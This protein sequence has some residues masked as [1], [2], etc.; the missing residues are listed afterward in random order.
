MFLKT[1]DPVL[2]YN[3]DTEF[4]I[5][6]QGNP[7]SSIYDSSCDGTWLL[8]KTLYENTEKWD[9]N[10]VN[11]FATSHMNTWLNNTYLNQIVAKDIIKKVNL[12]YLPGGT[13]SSIQNMETSVF[14][15]GL[16]EVGADS[17]TAGWSTMPV[18]GA[19]LD[20]FTADVTDPSGAAAKRKVSART[21]GTAY[22]WFRSPLKTSTGNVW[23][24]N[25]DGHFDGTFSAV[26]GNSSI[27]PAFIVS[28]D[29]M[30]AADGTIQV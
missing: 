25:P 15:L 20:Y 22:W 26:S 3:V 8:K 29:T 27:R 12:P 6:H 1:Y 5:V 23:N 19:K 2:E 9:T 21:G 7:D 11:N 14:L 4:I 18:D 24:V 10:N 17:S 28:S 30:V 16:V 13:A